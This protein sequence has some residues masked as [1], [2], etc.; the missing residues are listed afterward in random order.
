[1]LMRMASGYISCCKRHLRYACNYI[2]CSKRHLLLVLSVGRF[3]G[4][5]SGDRLLHSLHES[6]GG[7]LGLFYHYRLVCMSLDYWL[8][9]LFCHYGLLLDLCKFGIS[10]FFSDKFFDLLVKDRLM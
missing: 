2:L 7:S 4:H 8:S 9:E 5:C 10:S 3:L 1:M 6:L